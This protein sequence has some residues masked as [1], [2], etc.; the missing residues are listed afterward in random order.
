LQEAILK[1]ILEKKN[2]YAKKL[3]EY[4]RQKEA[5]MEEFREVAAAEKEDQRRKFEMTERSI[6]TKRAETSRY[7][8]GYLSN[9]ILDSVA[10]SNP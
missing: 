4:E 8:Y 2:E 5:E 10:I 7:F 9:C 6:V 1:F 3:A